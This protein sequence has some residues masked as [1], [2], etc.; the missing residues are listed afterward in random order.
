MR[1]K[2]KYLA[3]LSIFVLSTSLLMACSSNEV[4]STLP[5]DIKTV[6]AEFLREEAYTE[7]L[8]YTGYVDSEK[9]VDLAFLTSGTVDTIHVTEGEYVSKGDVL[10]SLGEETLKRKLSSQ[11]DSL[12]SYTISVSQQENNLKQAELQ[13][14]KEEK[15]YIAMDSLF[16]QGAISKIDY[17]NATYAYNTARI[18]YENMVYSLEAAKESLSQSRTALEQAEEEYGNSDLISP[19]DGLIVSIDTELNQ[20]VNIGTPV[21][22]VQK[23]LPVVRVGIPVDDYKQVNVDQPVFIIKDGEES[24]G[25]IAKVAKV[26]DQSTRTYA[27]EIS[28]DDTSLIYSSLVDIKIPLEKK[29]GYFVPLSSV[30]NINDINYVFM[31]LKDNADP[32]LYLVDQQEVTLGSIYNDKV[33]LLDVPQDMY[34]A[35]E[36]VKNLKIND[37]VRI[38]E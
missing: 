29:K 30:V 36:G 27:V 26:P 4:V 14:E 35:I 32:G 2:I 33:L 7:Y 16:N 12:E 10:I 8:E 25:K 23:D 28:V 1:N 31:L 11:R 13:F 5:A 6:R 15:N 22:T 17:E 24:K 21:I 3:L 38:I 37:R 18:N 9:S 19:L 34:V 20:S